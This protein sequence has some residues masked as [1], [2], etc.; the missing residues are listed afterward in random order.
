MT[1]LARRVELDVVM[2]CVLDSG[3]GDAAPPQCRNQFFDQRGLAAAGASNNG[4]HA[5]QPTLAPSSLPMAQAASPAP[6]PISVWRRPPRIALCP[7][8]RLR[9]TPRPNRAHTVIPATP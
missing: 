6:P 3:G 9:A 8:N 5:H 7:V 2:M 1:V 4:N